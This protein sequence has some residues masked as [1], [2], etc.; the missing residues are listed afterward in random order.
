MIS[1]CLGHSEGAFLR[2]YTKNLAK[3][4]D[5]AIEASQVAT[6]MIRSMEKRIAGGTDL[7]ECSHDL[8]YFK[9]SMT[10]LLK[11]LKEIADDELGID[12]KYK[13]NWPQSPR[14]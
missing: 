8:H 6:A 2:V 4:N 7:T 3:Q 12:T 9:G 11:V 10:D 5:H 14:P 13:I 1:R